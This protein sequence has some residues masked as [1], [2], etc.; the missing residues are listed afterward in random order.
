M[1]D[2]R[3][4]PSVDKLVNHPNAVA[5]IEQFGR[6]QVVDAIQMVLERIRQDPEQEGDELSGDVLLSAARRCSF[7]S[8]NPRLPG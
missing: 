8:R 4:L 6:T 2:L 5:L 3:K 1:I 7:S